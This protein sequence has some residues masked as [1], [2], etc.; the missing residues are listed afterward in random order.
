LP[1]KEAGKGPREK[2]TVRAS[3][4]A[5]LREGGYEVQSKRK[6][7]HPWEEKGGGRQR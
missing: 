4:I 6:P 5:Y 2:E 3:E 7:Q 1:R